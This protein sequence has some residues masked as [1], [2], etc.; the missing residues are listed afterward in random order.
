[1]KN[2]GWKGYAVLFIRGECSF[3]Q[4][5]RLHKAGLVTA[6]ASKVNWM[7]KGNR[8]FRE[9]AVYLTEQEA[10]E[11]YSKDVILPRV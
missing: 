11:R 5:E 3:R 2:T 7:G 10:L 9:L 6:C 8:P 4:I 1:M